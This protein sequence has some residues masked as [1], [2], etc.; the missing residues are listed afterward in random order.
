MAAGLVYAWILT[1]PA[2]GLMAALAY[3]LGKQFIR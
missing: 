2:A 1:I 3:W